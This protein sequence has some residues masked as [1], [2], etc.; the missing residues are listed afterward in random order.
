MRGLLLPVVVAA[1]LAGIARFDV[2]AA[3]E[4]TADTRI[5]AAATYVALGFGGEG[6]FVSDVDAGKTMDVSQEDRAALTE[7]RKQF[8]KWHRY[9]LTSFP[10]RAELLIAV[11]AGRSG[12]VGGRSAIG[13]R[14]PGTGLIGIDGGGSSSPDDMLTVYARTP[15][16]NNRSL[17]LVWRRALPNGLS[18]PQA[19]L[20]EQFRSAVEA[21]AK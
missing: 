13:G 14:P 6:G 4:V 2:D 18:G 9:V 15:G 17:S 10:D 19:P 12:H 5:L 20:F 11:R 21:A 8:E 1:S 7:I 3:Q 16:S